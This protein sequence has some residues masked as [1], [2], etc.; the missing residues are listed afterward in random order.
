MR[1]LHLASGLGLHSS[2]YLTSGLEL[3][4]LEGP[5]EVG[6]SFPGDHRGV[7]S[8]ESGILILL[9]ES[10]WGWRND[11]RLLQLSYDSA[12]LQS[13]SSGII[14]RKCLRIMLS[15]SLVCWASDFLHA[16]SFD[17]IQLVLR[18]SANASSEACILVLLLEVSSELDQLLSLAL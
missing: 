14:I 3:A 8:K 7:V 18:A 16:P 15:A 11:K 5:I 1:D 13:P 2:F 17:P 12:L 6:F 10:S 9:E 4:S